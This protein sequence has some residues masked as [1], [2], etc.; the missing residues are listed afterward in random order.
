[1]AAHYLTLLSSLYPYLH[2]FPTPLHLLLYPRHTS[3]QELYPHEA[4]TETGRTRMSSSMKPA[5][6]ARLEQLQE[7]EM[8]D[9]LGSGGDVDATLWSTER[10]RKWLVEVGL[11]DLY[12]TFAFFH[13]C[14]CTRQYL[15]GWEGAVGAWI[16]FVSLI[17]PPTTQQPPPTSLSHLPAASGGRAPASTC[18]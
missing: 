9:M 17:T 4:Q 2:I 1:M 7:E 10:V 11:P 13:G 3:S 18:R 6:S 16:E 14:G 15:A 12:G 8:L 5:D